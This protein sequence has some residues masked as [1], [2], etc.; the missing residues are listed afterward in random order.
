MMD[1]PVH[2]YRLGVD[3][4]GTHTDLVVLDVATGE[5]MVEKV[6]ST[7]ENP[8]LG[9]L[10]GVAR[11][12]ER[13]VDV[14]RMEFFA[15][16]TTI[17]T[18]ALLESRGARV[19]LLI[20]QGYRAVQEVQ[21]QARDGNLFD[22]FYAKPEPIA[23]QRLT[24][25]I[26]ERSDH[27][28]NVL[29]TLD[30]DAVR[31]AARELREA[32]VESI[33]VCFLF[34]FMNPAHEETARRLIHE[35]WPEV[36]VS[37]SSEV[38]PRIR[39]WPRLSTTL[40]NAYLEPVL[41]RYIAHLNKGLDESRLGTQQRFLMQ[42]NGG[43]MPFTAAVGGGKTVHTLLSGPAAGAQASAYLAESHAQRGLV[44]LDMGGTSAD[45]AFIE[46]GIPLEVTEGSIARRQVDVPALDMTTISAGGGSIAWVDGSGF[47]AI[48]PRSAGATPGPACYGRGGTEPAVTD[49]DLVCGCLNPDY[50]LGG[51][52]GLDVAASHAA[53]E[54]RIAQPLGMT[55]IEAAVG[56]RRI[57]DMRMADE[58]RVFAA[59]RGVDLTSFTLLPFG[60]AGAVHAAA[61]AE[62]LGIRHILVPPRPG[63][64]SAL[65]LL[66]TD[67]VHDY[68]RSDLKPLA[69][70]E[71]GHVESVFRQLEDKA[72]EEL[73]AEDMDVR[74][75][76]FLREMDLRYT[77]Q[78]YELRTSLD[79]LYQDQVNAATLAA[80]RQRFDER[81][82]QI[83]GH[84][85]ANRPVEVVSYRLRVRVAVPKYQPREQP[86][87]TPR[88]AADALK[89]RRQLYF[90]G[91][92][93]LDASVYER[94]R[95]DVGAVI[96]GP[97][98]VEQFDATTIVPPGWTGR[99]DGYHN[100]ML[101]HGEA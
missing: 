23:P 26:P 65:G 67:V 80:A 6:S 46:G 18:N 57:V 79:G 94:D 49:A 28:G 68:I 24:R 64:F 20:T 53:I 83:H 61:V 56:I 3:V 38:L 52:Q 69:D 81:H 85:A 66:C 97:A 9:V 88:P 71:A 90:A 14:R 17:T 32:G 31:Q 82:A 22:Y 98:I 43:V 78:G 93:A 92:E 42:S 74:S 89:G 33:A 96:A 48:G 19:G 87:G 4:G 41:V 5:L 7:P 21:N 13:G 1:A 25:E 75:A 2:R 100:L 84:A 54:S 51:S 10:N 27:A 15:H 16:G 72:R 59:R 73:A 45:I 30:H 35:V 39:E 50:F 37:L 8:A 29:V 40:L 12:V 11:F 34:S 36:H 101:E 55:V 47:L 70:L 44:T 62:E 95:L 76:R 86:G 63:A 58:V 91:P 60:G 77:G 99:V